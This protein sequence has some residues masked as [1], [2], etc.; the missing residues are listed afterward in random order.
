MEGLHSYLQ[1]AMQSSSQLAL[2]LTFLPFHSFKHFIE[3]LSGAKS[4]P[5][6]EGKIVNKIH[7]VTVLV[8]LTIYW[9]VE[10]RQRANEQMNVLRVGRRDEL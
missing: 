2:H 3:H 10:W 6:A 7:N 9:R 4:Y 1:T 8:E 5:G